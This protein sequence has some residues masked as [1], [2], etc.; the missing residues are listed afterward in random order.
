LSACP[1]KN[2]EA[3]GRRGRQIKQKNKDWGG[4]GQKHQVDGETKKRLERGKT[5]LEIFREKWERNTI[6]SSGIASWAFDLN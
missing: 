6:P 1:Q 3:L 2:V 5:P 4:L